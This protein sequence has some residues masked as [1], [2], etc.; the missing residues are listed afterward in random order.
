[1]RFRNV[2]LLAFAIQAVSSISNARAGCVDL[3]LKA[4][5]SDQ[6]RGARQNFR[7]NQQFVVCFRL[8]ADA[9][10]SL[11]DAPPHGAAQRIYPNVITHKNNASVAGE[12]L[13]AGS[14]HCFGTPGTFPLFFP[15]EQG[16]GE[17][18]ITIVATSS[19]EDQPPLNAYAIPGRSMDMNRM[20]GYLRSYNMSATCSSKMQEQ[21]IYSVSR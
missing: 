18:K 12:K 10:V 1:M 14:E 2:F 13:S 20:S 8:E 15:E 11:W 9:Y 19:L 16:T 3:W 5:Q 4:L 6:G 21:A 17:G 7:Q